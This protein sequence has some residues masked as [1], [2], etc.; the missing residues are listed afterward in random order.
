M[1]RNLAHPELLLNRIENRVG[2]GDPDVE[3][4]A[5]SVYSK[6]ELKA[7]DKAPARPSTPLLGDEGLNISQRNFLCKWTVRGG[8]SFILIGIGK[9]AAAEQ[10]LI[11]GRHFDTVNGMTLAEL[12]AEGLAFTWPSI[13]KILMGQL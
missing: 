10:I 13:Q 12:R 9:G 11:D 4:L 8:R 7:V 6:V 1:K 5:R 2:V 3:A